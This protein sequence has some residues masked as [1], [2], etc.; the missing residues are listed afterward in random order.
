MIVILASL[1]AAASEPV[2]AECAFDREAT[3]ALDFVP[4]D[5]TEGS[6]WRPLAD[7][8]C[9]IEAAELL[10]DW[11]AQH[12][13]DFDLTKPRDRAILEFLP[14]HEAQMWAFGGRNEV[15]LPIFES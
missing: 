13:A 7:A 3:L 2:R 14:W 6:G 12:R 10:R 1:A 11:Q 5:Q 8:Q 4:F 15:A 9:Y